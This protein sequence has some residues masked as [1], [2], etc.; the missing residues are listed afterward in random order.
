MGKRTVTQFQFANLFGDD[1]LKT[2][3]F[4][5]RGKSFTTVQKSFKDLF[6]NDYL[7]HK[8]F[9]EI[10]FNQNT[11]SLALHEKNWVGLKSDF[12]RKERLLVYAKTNVNQLRKLFDLPNFEIL[13]YSESLS[14]YLHREYFLAKQ[15]PSYN[16]QD[17]TY[18]LKTTKTDSTEIVEY[19]LQLQIPQFEWKVISIPTTEVEPKPKY[20]IG[21]ILPLNVVGFEVYT[22]HWDYVNKVIDPLALEEFKKKYKKEIQKAI[23]ATV[24]RKIEFVK[25]SENDLVYKGNPSGNSL[26]YSDTS[27]T[28]IV[29][30]RFNGMPKEDM[31]KNER[32]VPPAGLLTE[33][34]LLVSVDFQMPSPLFSSYA[35]VHLMQNR[36]IV[37]F[38]EAKDSQGNR[39]L[40]YK[41]MKESQRLSNVKD[42]QLSSPIPLKGYIP[43]NKRKETLWDKALVDG[44]YK[45]KAKKRDSKKDKKNKVSDLFSELTNNS[46][47]KYADVSQCIDLQWFFLKKH[48][49]DRYW[50]AYLFA[51]MRFFESLSAPTSDYKTSKRLVIPVK[52]IEV[53][54]R[55][56][57][58]IHLVKKEV[59]N[60]N[61]IKK[62]CY[63]STE[64]DSGELF[65]YLN[66][67]TGQPDSEGRYTSYTQYALNLNHW[68]DIHTWYIGHMNN[69]GYT[70]HVNRTQP[71]ATGLT[72]V[73]KESSVCYMPNG[74]I[75]K[76]PHSGWVNDGEQLDT[77]SY[78]PSG[79]PVPNLKGVENSESGHWNYVPSQDSNTTSLKKE[80]IKYPTTFHYDDTIDAINPCVGLE[81]EKYGNRWNKRYYDLELNNKKRKYVKEYIPLMPREVWRHTP[82]KARLAVYTTTVFVN[83]R[84]EYDEKT[85]SFFMDMLGFI[86]LI[87]S[88]IVAYIF[89]AI[90]APALKFGTMFFI[91]Y[92]ISMIGNKW[93]S[94]AF[95]LISIYSGISGIMSGSGGALATTA[96]VIA[97]LGSIL[98]ANQLLL[99][100]RQEEILKREVAKL[101]KEK[102]EAEKI[103]ERLETEQ[104]KFVSLDSFN[105]DIAN[106]DLVDLCYYMCSGEQV[107]DY[108][109][110]GKY[111]DVDYFIQNN[112]DRFK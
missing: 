37:Y 19:T 63:L 92:Q 9:K 38:F 4:G 56:S 79:I 105:I 102:A 16:I 22:D 49:Q 76:A 5:K 10:A 2:Y 82:S 97:V 106:E 28:Y 96:N 20:T 54:G 109:E 12:K 47:I 21:T 70:F 55:G 67:F 59:S 87:V 31:F 41:T 93:L 46:N 8:S 111:Y 89:P 30:Y 74:F 72:L 108:M 43:A 90:A 1:P 110:L 81:L 6:I 11:S 75:L 40:F 83:I 99:G 26:N 35:L 94:L 60:G 51:L 91:G 58:R 66:R 39:H 13:D 103:K 50:Q 57:Y 61:P 64:P 68:Y 80:Q 86:V 112:Y 53:N 34:Y 27:F 44:N 78:L 84:I 69:S 95:I 98:Q 62:R 85:R 73:T 33:Q 25:R 32:Y 52:D 18:K 101:N 48:R 7:K 71:I 3:P 104:N 29:G 17:K 88:I 42:V 24:D 23:G 65:L 15:I 45:K 14:G 36:D 100:M 77:H 107:Y